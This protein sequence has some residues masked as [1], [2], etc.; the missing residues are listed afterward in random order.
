M[1][2]YRLGHWGRYGILGGLEEETRWDSDTV[3]RR[4]LNDGQVPPSLNQYQPIIVRATDKKKLSDIGNERPL[5]LSQRA[6]DALRQL[7][8][9]NGVLY[10]LEAHDTPQPYWLFYITNVI[11]CLDEVRS[12]GAINKDVSDKYPE[13]YSTLHSAFFR[14]EALDVFNTSIFRLPYYRYIFV[15]EKFRTAVEKHKLVGFELIPEGVNEMKDYGRQTIVLNRSVKPMGGGRELRRPRRPTVKQWIQEIDRIEKSKDWMALENLR[16][17]VN[18]SFT[19]RLDTTGL[20]DFYRQIALAELSQQEVSAL[21]DVDTSAFVEALGQSIGNLK[22]R[23]AAGQEFSA[24]YYE[25]YFDNGPDNS[26]DFFICTE[27]AADSDYWRSI[28]DGEHGVVSGPL[29]PDY[30]RFDPDNT[31][32]DRKRMIALEIADGLQAAQLAEAWKDA[33]LKK[34]PLAYARHEEPMTC[35]VK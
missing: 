30:F 35:I 16:N 19:A 8:D 7:L 6:V 15:D 14:R 31:W 26:G 24:I 33:K 22:A 28:F 1:N 21:F 29:L 18:E 32:N 34:W 25:Y 20:R 17:S 10:P 9:G 23:I 12:E 11:D 5:I 27:Y 3:A 4:V 2:Y 13:K